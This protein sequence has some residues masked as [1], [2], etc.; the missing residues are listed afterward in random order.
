MRAL[1]MLRMSCSDP[2][3]T[4]RSSG[5]KK[6]GPNPSV[7]S[8]SFDDNVIPAAGGLARFQAR[9]VFG[10]DFLP[11][12]RLCASQH[13]ASGRLVETAG[14]HL[15]IGQVGKLEA[16][17]TLR[18]RIKC[19]RQ[20]LGHRWQLCQFAGTGRRDEFGIGRHEFETARLKVAQPLAA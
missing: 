1:R 5:T 7:R 15:N 18:F 8:D 14:N 20:Y 13:N 16:M 19:L 6:H 10:K 9:K 12:H 17:F 2:A 3:T 11:V 4:V